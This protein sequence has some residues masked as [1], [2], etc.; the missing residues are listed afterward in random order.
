MNDTIHVQVQVV[1][2]RV[3][4]LDLFKYFLPFCL[5]LVHS[6]GHAKRLVLIVLDTITIKIDLIR[7]CSLA[8]LLRF[9]LFHSFLSLVLVLE[10]LEVLLAERIDDHLGVA[11]G[12]PSE[13]CWNSHLCLSL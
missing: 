9:C 10:H 2:L 1:N 8:L 13:E 5:L 4:P 12:Q 6:S 3:V 11:D 7:V